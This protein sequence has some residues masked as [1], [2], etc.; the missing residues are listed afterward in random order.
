MN[1]PRKENFEIEIREAVSRDI[2]PI[3]E[4]EV[5]CFKDP[6]SRAAIRDEVE[7]NPLSIY[8]VAEDLKKEKAIG[9]AGLWQVGDEGHITNVAVA[10]DYRRNGIGDKVVSKLLMT[11]RS[12]G[13]KAFTLEVRVSNKGAQELYKRHGFENAG[14]RPGYYVDKEDAM[15]MWLYD[16]E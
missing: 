13:I 8:I 2:D 7:R 16:K 4:L 5:I 12:R 10:P 9:Y 15:I 6:W 1:K 3:A 11:A 14:I